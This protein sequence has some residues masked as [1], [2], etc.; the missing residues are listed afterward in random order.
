MTVTLHFV[1]RPGPC[2]WHAVT[3]LEP[4]ERVEARALLED[5]EDVRDAE[6]EAVVRVVRL[7]RAV[8][9][10][11]VHAVLGEQA[12]LDPRDAERGHLTGSHHTQW[13]CVCLTPGRP[14]R[15]PLGGRGR[16]DGATHDDVEVVEVRVLAAQQHRLEAVDEHVEVVVS[17][18]HMI[19][20]GITIA[21]H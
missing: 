21:S 17:W 14:P 18:H 12:R 2:I 4:V 19:A 20:H 6:R 15:F 16:K 13:W 11:L 3:D 8:D 1:K 7:A 5:R 9:L 10:L